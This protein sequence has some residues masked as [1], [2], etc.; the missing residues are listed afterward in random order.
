MNTNELTRALDL[1]VFTR[2]SQQREV[3]GCYIGDLLSR[4]MSRAKQGDAWITV[5]PN[6]NVAAVA[7][8][9]EV[10]CVILPEDIKP[11]SELLNKCEKE[12][13]ALFGSNLSAYE[14]ALRIRALFV[15]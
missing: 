6:V 8:L 11:D 13:I 5:M 12:N 7:V 9:T 2:N 14:L 4:A 1:N 10:S 3:T 15:G